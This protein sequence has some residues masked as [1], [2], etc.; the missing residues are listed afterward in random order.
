M[1]GETI[2]HYRILEKLGGGGMGVVYKAEDTKLHRFVALKFLP[3]GFAPDLQALSRFHREAQAASALNHSN[4]CTIYEIGEHEGQPFIAMEF[5]DGQTLK[6]RIAGKPLPLEQVLELGIEIA[7]ALDVAHAKGIAHRDIKPANI[8]VTERGHAKILDFGLAKLAPAGGAVNLSARPTA[9]AED[10]LTSPGSAVGTIAYMSPEQARGEEL[11]ARTDLFS[12]GAVLYEMA[13]G[14]MAF[15]GNTAAVVHDAILNRAPTPLARVNPDISP[16]LE[17]IITKALEKDRRLRYQNASDIRTDLQRLKRDTDS[18]RLPARTNAGTPTRPGMRWQ[19]IV[20]GAIA[21]VV[22]TLAAALAR[23]VVAPPRVKR[24]HQITHIGTVVGNQSLLVSGSRI[25]FVANE[26]GENQIRY[27]SVDDDAVFPVGKPSLQ[28]GLQDIFPS[29][30]ELLITEIDQGFPL[31]AW[32]RTLW[33][34]PV[35][36]VTPRRVGNVF[37]DDAAWS[38]DGRTI[39]Y[40]NEPEQSLNLVDGDGGNAR[41]LASLPGRPFKPRWSPDGKLIRTSV[42]DPRGGGISLWQLDASGR[43]V[44]R[45]LSSWSSSSRAWAGRWTRDGHYFLFT[46]LQAGTRNIWALR[47]KR[48]VLR[49][50]RTQP[51]QLTDGPVNFYLP[52][53]SDD[54]K[55]IYAVGSQPHGQLMRYN[56]RSRQFE[57]YANGLSVDHVAFSRDGKWMAYETYPEG[58]LARSHLDG[59]ER[60]QLTFAPMRALS[61]VW[62][63]DGSQIA[64][65]ATVNPG[66]PQKIYLVSANGSSPRLVVPGAGGEQGQPSWSPDGQSLL[67]PSSD[68]SGSEWALHSLNMKTEKDTVLPGTLEIDGG[69]LSP[70]GRY[71]TG[72]SASTHSLALYDMASGT[73]R[74]LAEAADYPSWSPDGKYVY[75]STLMWGQFLGPQKATIYRVKVADGSVE[76]VAPTPTFPLAGNWGVWSG[77]APDGSVLVLRELGTSDIYALDADLP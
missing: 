58:A 57:P 15:P 23:P 47:D 22:L 71:F 59:S 31:S 29:G 17:R 74:Q 7:D 75:Y 36:A 52:V 72:I 63:P 69:S 39:I 46:G 49:R 5:L 8:F 2:A 68:E 56:A 4:I 62:S 51:V 43:N 26:K 73:T 16:E 18:A 14:R 30:D 60:L 66:G 37:A 24:V 10:L 77:L 44:T 34:L 9:T 76:R 33:R 21:V 25:Y 67:F 64:F 50:N 3:D 27:I 1:I 13:A 41:K 48:D 65:M 32:R 54:S 45:M 38:P 61:P 28:I 12:F 35:P 19:T 53:A 55:T 70:D 11:D 40:T 6:H 20:L 42:L